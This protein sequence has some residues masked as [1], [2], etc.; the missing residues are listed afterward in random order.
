MYI[1]QTFSSK[2]RLIVTRSSVEKDGKRHSVTD[3]R[4]F[5]ISF[6]SFSRA[7]QNNVAFSYFSISIFHIRDQ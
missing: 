2:F 4:Q 7:D 6:V 3:D 1:R 5:C